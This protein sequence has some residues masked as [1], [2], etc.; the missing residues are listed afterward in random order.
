MPAA[1]TAAVPG[2]KT[3]TAPAAAAAV[4]TTAAAT[5]TSSASNAKIT[6][7]IV[8]AT[9]LV[10]SHIVTTALTDDRFDHVGTL[11]RSK[12]GDSL[13][14][15]T[16][17]AGHKLTAV[18]D[19]ESAGWGDILATKVIAAS[20]AKSGAGVPVFFSALGTTLALAGST[21]A[22]RK[23]DV[24]L[25]VALAKAAHG[26]GV[27]TAVVVS[28]MSASAS[29]LMPYLK[30]KG[31]MER[32][33]AAVGF[34][35]LVVLR[36]G[37]LIGNRDAHSRSSSKRGTEQ[38]LTMFARASRKLGGAT[39]NSFTD[40]WAQD[41]DVVARA[42]IRAAADAVSGKLGASGTT[43]Y[44]ATDIMRLGRTEWMNEGAA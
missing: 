25:P 15:T 22:Q 5:A 17:H 23:V 6:A 21:A 10:G 18:D 29:S 43:V 16:A 7:I 32:D 4:P 39:G 37:V 8:G 14:K 35:H 28:S 11:T 1:T 2:N 20:A 9:G 13:A 26:A 3:G 38:L 34:D 24:D 44:N 40:K 36:P 41:A 12:F 30:M 33:V 42:A 27:K 19:A 31:E